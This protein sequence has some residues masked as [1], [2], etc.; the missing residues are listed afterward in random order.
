M[1][2]KENNV[3]ETVDLVEVSS[4]TFEECQRYLKEANNALADLV[5]KIQGKESD[6]YGV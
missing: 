1:E 6:K 3:L 4:T 2:E 5:E